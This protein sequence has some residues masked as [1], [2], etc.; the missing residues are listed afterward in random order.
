MRVET[1]LKQMEVKRDPRDGRYRLMEINARHWMW[2]SLAAA[3]GVNLSLAAYRDAIGQP[4]I[5][6]RQKDGRK[7]SV[8]IKDFSDG[9]REVRR[10]ELGVVH[11][12]GSYRG[13]RVDGVLSFSDPLPGAISAGR[14]VRKG[15]A[16]RAR[17]GA[18]ATPDDA[19][20]GVTA[21]SDTEQR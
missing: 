3:C 9:V 12:L 17:R 8:A 4:F 11:W 14:I 5:A 2:H 21:A 19:G 6:P 20:D 18:P 7:W 15:L 10:H 13:L 1:L 16:R